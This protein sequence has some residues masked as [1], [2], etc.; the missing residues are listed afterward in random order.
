MND[1]T[2]SHLFVTGKLAA[3]ALRE[4][5][6]RM[7]P[8]FAYEVVVLNI[9]VTA[10][11]KTEWIARQL[12]HAHGCDRVMISGWCQGELSVIEEKLGVE[13]VRGPKD[14]RDL[15]PFFG[16]ERI[17]EDYGSYRMQIVAEI[18]EAYHMAWEDILARA[19]YYRACGAD[20][21]DLGCPVDGTFP[22]VEQ[23][24]A[25]LK[26]RDF[27]VSLDTFDREIILRADGAGM[28]LLLSIN[29]SNMEIAPRLQ[30]KV[31]VV[32]DFDQG[33]ASLERNVAQLEA[34]GVEYVVDPILNPIHFGFTE[35]IC[36]YYEAR[37]RYPQAEMLMGVANLTELTEADSTGI[38]AVMA[39]IVAE[40]GIEYVLTTE[41][42][43]WARGSVRELDIARR[44]MDY[45]QRHRVLPKF[46]DD[47]LVTIKEDLEG[48]T[49]SLAD[50]HRMQQ[51]VRDRNWRI[52][53]GEGQ[54]H[55]FNN[56]RFVSGTDPEEIFSRLDVQDGPHAFYLGQELERAALAVRLGKRYTQENPLDWGYLSE[57]ACGPDGR[58]G[59]A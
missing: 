23:V 21:I 55:V 41:V 4:T 43:G 47:R 2:R 22:H 31:V 8:D 19:E 58:S 16:Q 35:S 51:R 42:I 29:G 57:W 18:V 39:G 13:V 40:L 12:E 50:L 3:D 59:D 17:E 32:P 27:V 33:L 5:L 56:E 36:R 38:H 37:R 24:V 52:F 49:Y 7:A 14:L 1:K 26:A 44:M 48:Y 10:L 54:I 30:C 6:E 11:M 15:P 34:W 45:A 53:T 9:S 28:D 20:V 25:G 46:I